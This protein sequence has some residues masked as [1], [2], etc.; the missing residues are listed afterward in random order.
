MAELEGILR[1]DWIL[2][3]RDAAD[4]TG[5]GPIGAGTRQL[6]TEMRRITPSLPAEPP[7]TTTAATTA[8]GQQPGDLC[9]A[10]RISQPLLP[11][12]SLLNSAN[13]F[14]TKKTTQKYIS[15]HIYYREKNLKKSK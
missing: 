10:R 1:L 7:A 12:T 14:S 4:A 3:G 9:P 15:I 13:Q 6:Q 11:V 8:E 2:S 5:A